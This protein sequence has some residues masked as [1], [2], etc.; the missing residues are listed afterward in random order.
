M[1]NQ[2]G[3]ALPYHRRC[4]YNGCDA[5]AG[6][7]DCLFR[8]ALGVGL[9]FGIVNNETLMLPFADEA[10]GVVGF[11]IENEPTAVHLNQFAV[12]PHLHADGGGGAMRHIDMCAHGALPFGEEG[13]D[14][15]GTGLF[16]Q[17]YHH[18]GGKHLCQTAAHA[19]GGHLVGDGL[20]QLVFYSWGYHFDC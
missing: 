11:D 12:A 9:E 1:K 6:S 14:A 4:I 15:F 2:R 16:H 19:V 5:D 7:W 10:A 8:F 18:G 20:S 17:G 3:S 13:S